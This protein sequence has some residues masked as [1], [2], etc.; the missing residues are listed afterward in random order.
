[1][2]HEWTTWSK[3]ISI[4]RNRL[5]QIFNPITPLPIGGLSASAWNVIQPGCKIW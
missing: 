5:I 1:M 4:S 2:I 3:D